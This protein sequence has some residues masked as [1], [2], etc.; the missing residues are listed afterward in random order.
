M[1]LKDQIN[2]YINLTYEHEILIFGKNDNGY[3]CLELKLLK[4]K[5][6][7]TLFEK[8]TYAHMHLS[9]NTNKSYFWLSVDNRKAM[10]K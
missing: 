4:P 7:L 5:R 9:Y 6:G 3:T 8:E 2:V 10:Q 1:I